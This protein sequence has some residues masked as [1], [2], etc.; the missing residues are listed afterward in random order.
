MFLMSTAEKVADSVY[1]FV[2]AVQPSGSVTFFLPCVH[3]GSIGLSHGLF[4][5][6]KQTNLCT[7]RLLF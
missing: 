1:K 2:T 6:S 4:S 3:L 5:G 7:P